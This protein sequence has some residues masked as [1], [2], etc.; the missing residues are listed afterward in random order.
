[1]PLSILNFSALKRAVRLPLRSWLWLA[2][3]AICAAMVYVKCVHVITAWFPRGENPLTMAVGEL[4]E[5]VEV[6][7]LGSS[8]ALAGVNP[9]YIDV[10]TVSLALNSGNYEV[11]EI[12]LRSHLDK[13]PNVKYA[14]VELDNTCLAL[15]RL[16]GTRDFRELYDLGADLDY[17]PKPWM[18]KFRQRVLDH[19]LVKPIV[20]YQRMTP[21]ELIYIRKKFYSREEYQKIVV[22][23]SEDADPV[24]MNRNNPGKRVPGHTAQLAKMDLERLTEIAEVELKPDIVTDERLSKNADALSRLLELLKERDIQPV[25]IRYPYTFAYNRWNTEEWQAIGAETEL[26]LREMYK[27]EFVYWTYS[28]NPDF[29]YDEFSDAQ[30]LNKWGAIKFSKMLNEKICALP[31]VTVSPP[32]Q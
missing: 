9:S 11:Q 27:D 15:D 13:V 17:F 22:V 26:F 6:L 7:V 12:L 28:F 2:L 24:P 25:F 10:P 18:W 31:G 4:N 23:K 20:F 30:H 1:M 3:I 16:S 5:N 19:D 21:Y 32:V 29:S 14:I 8:H